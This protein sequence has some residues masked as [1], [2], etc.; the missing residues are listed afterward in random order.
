MLVEWTLEALC[1]KAEDRVE[2]IEDYKSIFQR[3]KSQ[4]SQLAVNQMAA[5]VAL[6][7][8]LGAGF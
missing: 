4:T 1:T 8:P 2:K 5:G 3:I 6:N 7:R